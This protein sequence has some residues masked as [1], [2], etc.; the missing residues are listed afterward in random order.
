MCGSSSASYVGSVSV[1][2][3]RP[4]HP[5]SRS[6]SSLRCL[7]HT[8]AEVR[9]ATRAMRC[10]RIRATYDMLCRTRHSRRHSQATGSPLSG[11][12][13]TTAGRKQSGHSSTPVA[14]VRPKRPIDRP[15]LVPVC[16]PACTIRIEP[17]A[18]FAFGASTAVCEQREWPQTFRPWGSVWLVETRRSSST[19][20]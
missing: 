19:T 14:T 11:S 17:P 8:E 12:A 7:Q 4:V 5:A 15:P 10:D 20:R 13:S 1:T 3:T 9:R 2:A 6:R 18:R 16:Q